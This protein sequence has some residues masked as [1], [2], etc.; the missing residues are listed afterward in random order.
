VLLVAPRITRLG[1]W[2]RAKICNIL[3]L[4]AKSI[5]TS[6]APSSTRSLET[7]WGIIEHDVTKFVGHYITM[8]VVSE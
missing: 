4:N 8:L 1:D 2:E 5:P 6:C 3:G 7:K